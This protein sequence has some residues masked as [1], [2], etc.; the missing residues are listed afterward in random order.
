MRA[1]AILA[2][3]L[4]V[5]AVVGLVSAA[6]TTP[7]PAGAVSGIAMAMGDGM[8][9]CEENSPDCGDMKFCPFMVACVAKCP[10]NVPAIAALTTPMAVP[11]VLIPEQDWRTSGLAIAPPVRPPEA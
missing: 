3:L 7:A 10:Q 11:A 6:F 4:T 2:R 8:P 5:L 9:P 1:L